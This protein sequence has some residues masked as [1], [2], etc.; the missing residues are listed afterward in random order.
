[1]DSEPTATVT[2]RAV[3]VASLRAGYEWAVFTVDK[4]RADSEFFTLSINSSFGGY[5]FAWSHPGCSWR[6]FLAR[7]N[8]GYVSSKMV[9]GDEVFDGDA[10]A[11]SV[12]DQIRETRRSG[13]CSAEEAREEWDALPAHFESECDFRD[14]GNGTRMFRDGWYEMHTTCPSPRLRD[15]HRLYDVFWDAFAKAI[16]EQ[17]GGES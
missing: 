6:K 7:L 11:Q 9:G 4:P 3:D 13:D 8:R 16:S 14:W 17:E 10:T 12:R 5:V 15:F 1:M 2:R